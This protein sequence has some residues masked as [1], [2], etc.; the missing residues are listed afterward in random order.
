MAKKPD[1]SQMKVELLAVL[2]VKAA[3]IPEWRWYRQLLDWEGDGTS[4]E[5]SLIDRRPRAADAPL[6]YV[7]LALRLFAE[8]GTPVPT[9]PLFEY[10]KS[11]RQV[12]GKTEKQGRTN[13]QSALSRDDRIAS[14][15]WQNTRAWWYSDKPLPAVNG[16]TMKDLAERSAE[17]GATGH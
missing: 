2:D 7:E 3:D 17:D 5:T 13:V 15:S 12:H 4:R 8:R 9:G 14:V 16:V 6:P 11:Q 10:V 1:Y